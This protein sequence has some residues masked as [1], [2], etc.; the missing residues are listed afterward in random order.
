MKHLCEA[1]VQKNKKP[2]QPN[3]EVSGFNC[4]SLRVNGSP[5]DWPSYPLFSYPKTFDSL[6]EVNLL[7]APRAI[8]RMPTD[9]KS[10]WNRAFVAAFHVARRKHAQN[11]VLIRRRVT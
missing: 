6:P 5:G 8:H 11:A 7:T 4:V 1:M 9:Q 2:T 10:I 3:P